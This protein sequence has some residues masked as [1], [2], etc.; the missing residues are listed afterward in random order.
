MAQA[1][2]KQFYNS[3]AWKSCRSSYIARRVSIDGGMCEDCKERLGYIVHHRIELT[4]QNIKNPY[5]SLNH[6]NLRYVCKVC[7][8]TYDGH[9]VDGRKPL[10]CVFDQ[11]GQVAK[12]KR[13]YAPSTPLEFKG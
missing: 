7:H 13:R 6:S 9:G 1:W 12:D 11:S 8:D 10:L 3:K 4:E 2:A 5:V